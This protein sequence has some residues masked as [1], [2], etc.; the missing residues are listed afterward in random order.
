MTR[1]CEQCHHPTKRRIRCFE[2]GTM[3]CRDCAEWDP[4]F[5]AHSCLVISKFMPAMGKT[6]HYTCASP[7]YREM[8]T[9]RWERAVVAAA[10]MTGQR[11]GTVR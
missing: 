8:S 11:K 5:R 3:I 10:P 4:L 7:G 1:L 9:D 6:Y 2:C